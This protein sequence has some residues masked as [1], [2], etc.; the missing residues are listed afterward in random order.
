MV[1]PSCLSVDQEVPSILG[2]LG[3]GT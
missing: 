1:E 2:Q 3:T